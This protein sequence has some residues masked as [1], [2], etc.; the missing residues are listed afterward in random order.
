M[1]KSG[2]SDEWVKYD[3]IHKKLCKQHFYG[4]I[5]TSGKAELLIKYV[6]TITLIDATYTTTTLFFLCVRVHTNVNYTVV[7]EFIVQS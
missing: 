1:G 6:N 3:G 2:C 5:K 7:A 4:F